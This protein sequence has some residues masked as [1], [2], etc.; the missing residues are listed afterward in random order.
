MFALSTSLRGAAAG[1]LSALFI[2]GPALGQDM[3][4]F[5]IGT[6]GVGGTYYPIG[7][8]I[9]SAISNPP[10]SRPCEMGG[11]CGV[12]GLVAITQTSDGS[13]A[14]LKQIVSGG[15]ESGFVQSDIAYWA[16][17]G[18]GTFAGKKAETSIRAIANLYPESMHVVVRADSRIESVADLK[19]RTVS[20][21][22]PGSG[23]LVDARLLLK[24]YGL[25]EKSDLKPR[26]LQSDAAAARLIDGTLDAFITVAGYPSAA[27]RYAID[28]KKARI[29][30]LSGKEIDGL[31]KRQTY[32][33]RSAIPPGVYRNPEAIPTISV[34]AIW[35][36]SARTDPE[37][38]YQITRVLWNAKSRKLL[39]E[40]HEK[41]KYIRLETAIQGLGIPLHEGAERYYR[42]VGLIK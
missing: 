4:F 9:A 23:T 11:S 27:V 24:A 22:E 7:G 38:V 5:R 33:T 3:R 30:P 1:L 29:L 14:N 34:N 20:L 8:I 19:G 37:L 31:L 39:D 28:S 35:V 18:T 6:G 32:F 26:Y 15:F 42:E 10:G 25:R 21:D 41:G 40:G 2:A 16:Y 36:V 17:T 13:V 12:P